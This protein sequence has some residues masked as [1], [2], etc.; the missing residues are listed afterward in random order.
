[1]AFVDFAASELIMPDL[2]EDEEKLKAE[3][4]KSEHL[5]KN[6]KSQIAH[7]HSIFVPY[8]REYLPQVLTPKLIESIIRLSGILP[9]AT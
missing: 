8:L 5:I 6:S 7:G 9:E 4:Y 2:R 3:D 1:M